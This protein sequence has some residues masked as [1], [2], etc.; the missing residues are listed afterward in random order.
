MLMMVQHLDF[1]SNQTGGEVA[2]QLTIGEMPT[3]NH[4]DSTTQGGNGPSQWGFDVDGNGSSARVLIDDG[5]PW[6]NIV[7]NLAL[8]VEVLSTRIDH[9]IMHFAL[10]LDTL[11]VVVMVVVV[12]V[13]DLLEQQFYM[14]NNLQ[15][16]MVVILIVDHGL[17]EH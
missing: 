10:S 9:H 12:I 2:H 5:P 8:E 13:V 16:L 1:C 3:H 17:I 4:F 11:Q 7:G 14:I 15:E 6:N